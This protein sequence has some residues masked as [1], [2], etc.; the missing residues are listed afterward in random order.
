MNNYN[1]SM[2][3]FLGADELPPG[4]VNNPSQ[5]VGV[6]FKP[7]KAPRNQKVPDLTGKKATICSLD[8]KPIKL[9]LETAER[10]NVYHPDLFSLSSDG[11]YVTHDETGEVIKLNVFYA[12]DQ[13]A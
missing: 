7:G 10:I 5:A 2:P 3:Q 9:D 1:D 11:T 13:F 12:H 8:I 4:L 6:D